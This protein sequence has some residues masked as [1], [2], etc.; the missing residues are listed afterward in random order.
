MKRLLIAALAACLATPVAA[1][2]VSKSNAGTAVSAGRVL[3]VGTTNLAGLNVVSGASAGYVMLF[4]AASVP[5][6]GAVA[7]L[8]CI[9]I[10]PNTTIDLNFRGSP[11][12]FDVG[13]VIVFSTT[14]CFT[15]TASATAFLAGD[16]Q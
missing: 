8:R 2:T 1:Q 16:V 11:L 15:K 14:G 4:D 7:P 12:R 9:T 3:R 10:A 13:A 6:D 5:A